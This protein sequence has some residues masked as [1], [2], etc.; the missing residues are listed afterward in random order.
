MKLLFLNGERGLFAPRP[1]DI[2]CFPDKSS[3]I[4]KPGLYD[5]EIVREKE[6]F[7]FVDG[8]PIE[9]RK[10]GV[11]EE[12]INLES[13]IKA[14]TC[15]TLSVP[16][17]CDGRKIG[18]SYIYH[19]KYTD[20]VYFYIPGDDDKHMIY[21]IG[22]EPLKMNYLISIREAFNHHSVYEDINSKAD[23]VWKSI[24][25]SLVEIDD[26]LLNFAA[27]VAI[28]LVPYLRDSRLY[29]TEVISNALVKRCGKYLI[30]VVYDKTYAYLGN[31]HLVSNF[32]VLYSNVVYQRFY[33]LEIGGDEIISS[34]SKYFPDI[35]TDIKI[36]TGNEIKEFMQKNAIGI[37]HDMHD[38][39]NYDS[40]V[41]DFNHF[42]YAKVSK[43]IDVFNNTY[44]VEIFDASLLFIEIL[45]MKHFYETCGEN[46]SWYKNMESLIKKVSDELSS[47]R[48]RIGKNASRNNMSEIKKLSYDAILDLPQI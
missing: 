1:Y 33:M 13:I 5:C 43:T 14:S 35:N 42:N 21:D 20:D 31:H 18:D 11:D 27:P 4:T 3:K 32:I 36:I 40:D 9:T 10:A 16:C 47:F 30:Q 19:D 2:I 41:S 24:K 22:Y 23:V 48:K 7:A 37:L 15:N 44:N 28:S 26:N 45:Q 6:K 39:F 29:K 46:S 17:K 8:E 34:M 38:T 25:D 12:K